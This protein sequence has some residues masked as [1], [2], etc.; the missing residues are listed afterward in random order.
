MQLLK[1][2]AR[3][4]QEVQD[5]DVERGLASIPGIPEVMLCTELHPCSC[6]AFYLSCSSA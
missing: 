2:Q 6:S 4:F 1:V 3:S 5:A